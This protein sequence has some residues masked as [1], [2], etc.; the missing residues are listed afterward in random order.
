M[1]INTNLPE[2]IVLLQASIWWWW[3]NP[4]KS[5]LNFGLKFG[6]N[7]CFLLLCGMDPLTPYQ[8]GLKESL[9]HKRPLLIN[10]G[11]FLKLSTKWESAWKRLSPA[12]QKFTFSSAL[13]VG[14]EW[15]RKT[16]LYVFGFLLLNVFPFLPSTDP[17]GNH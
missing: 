13:I 11:A 12:L 10:L 2:L 1:S 16:H 14:L 3:G 8:R 5:I 7:A 6:L 4:L 15:H 9:H 17:G